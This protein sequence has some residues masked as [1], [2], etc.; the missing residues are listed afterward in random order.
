MPT[1]GE[2]AII[3]FDGLKEQVLQLSH[4]QHSPSDVSDII[5]V[6]G[7][8]AEV[9]LKAV[10]LPGRNNRDTFETFINALTPQGL[11]KPD[12]DNLHTLRKRWNDAKHDPATVIEILEALQILIDARSSIESIVNLGLGRVADAAAPYTKRVFW[13]AMWD[14][15][16]GADTEV[17]VIL[18][19]VS[20]DWLGPPTFDQIYLDAFRIEEML[21]D[22]RHH[23]RLMAGKGIIPDTQIESFRDDSDFRGA[24]VFEGEYRP[25]ITTLAN[26]E[27]RQDLIP[28]LNRHDSG[29]SMLIAFLMATLDVA[30][31][32]R[33]SGNVLR[34]EVEKQA[35]LGYGVPSKM[36]S[37][38]T[39]AGEMAELVEQ[40]PQVDWAKL[41]GPLFLSKSEYDAKVGDALAVHRSQHIAI[42][43]TYT[44]N[45]ATT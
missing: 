43:P 27:K 39:Y 23:G 8:K 20:G 30:V 15:I 2:L 36:P 3:E 17:H 42:D 12:V 16:I 1:Q 25:L 32:T 6:A 40:L 5:S 4:S 10:A 34:N 26:Y 33:S 18:P 37:S 24:W 41:R 29:A 35:A 14:H 44:V 19:G 22:L 31:A 21:D 13:L 28:G 45:L 38:V 7:A 11:A 9:F